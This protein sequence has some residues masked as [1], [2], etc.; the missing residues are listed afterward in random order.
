MIP[1]ITQQIP[2]QTA[3]HYPIQ[4]C[5]KPGLFSGK[6]R[7]YDFPKGRLLLR[8]MEDAPLTGSRSVTGWTAGG[9]QLVE[10]SSISPVGAVCPPSH[11]APPQAPP[12]S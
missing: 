1:P 2:L 9:G 5:I 12:E 10:A 4:L 8:G 3:V 11:Q 6:N 7:Y